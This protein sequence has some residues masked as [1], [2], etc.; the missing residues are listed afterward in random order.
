MGHDPDMGVEGG[1][2]PEGQQVAPLLGVDQ[3]D[4]LAGA[5]QCA[6]GRVGVGVRRGP[7]SPGDVHGAQEPVPDGSGGPARMIRRSP[8]FSLVR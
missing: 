6:V 5:E 8:G 4:L 1:A 2:G 3:Q 7:G